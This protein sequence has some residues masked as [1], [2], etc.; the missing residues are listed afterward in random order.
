[1]L[2]EGLKN[3]SFNAKMT[4]D[5]VSEMYFLGKIN[6]KFFPVILSKLM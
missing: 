5:F 2:I 1:M 6:N 4:Y 3:F